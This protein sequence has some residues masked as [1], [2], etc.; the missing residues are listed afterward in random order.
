MDLH[1][2]NTGSYI[3]EATAAEREA[4]EMAAQLDGGAGVILVSEDG[5]ILEAHDSGAP[6]ARRCYVSE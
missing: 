5:D 1:D 3:R 2:Y 6:S 4:S